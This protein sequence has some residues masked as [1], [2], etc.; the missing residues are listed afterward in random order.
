MSS[1]QCP[2]VY[3]SPPSYE[4]RS[5]EVHQWTLCSLLTGEFPSLVTYYSA[6]HRPTLT[7]TSRRLPDE[8]CR[9]GVSNKRGALSELSRSGFSLSS[10]S[11]GRPL[12][13][14]TDYQEQWNTKSSGY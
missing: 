5:V 12:R 10:P 9:Q 11:S 4:S 3:F 2:E 14:L 6:L 7:P 8:Y 1:V 13:E